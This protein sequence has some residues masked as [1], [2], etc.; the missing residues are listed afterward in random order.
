MTGMDLQRLR[1]EE[2]EQP[3]P[4]DDEVLVKIHAT[5]VSRTDFAFRRAKPFVFYRF[6]TG[7]RRP[8]RRILGSELAGEIEYVGVAVSALA[9]GDQVFG[10]SGL[11]FG[12]YA[13]LI[14]LPE[15]ALLG[16]K[17]SGM[18]FEEAGGT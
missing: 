13:E 1:V 4:G 12:A 8:K 14:C 9:V 16:P 5:T 10:S 6:I 7:P 2:V 17:P 15:N 3:V 11:G 18:S